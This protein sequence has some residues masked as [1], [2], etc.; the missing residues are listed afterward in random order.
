MDTKDSPP[1]SVPD[2]STKSNDD[3]EDDKVEVGL[4]TWLA[5]GAGC[6]VIFSSFYNA[7]GISS[8]T[9]TVAAA[10]GGTE[11]A[12][13]ITWL[14][15]AFECTVLALASSISSISDRFGRREILI[16]GSL[17]CCG[18]SSL[19]PN[20]F[21][22]HVVI[23]GSVMTGG[24]F[25]NQ[26]IYYS[27]PSEVLPRRYRGIGQTLT[28]SAGA[29]GAT[30][31]LLLNGA[32]IKIYGVQ[33]FRYNYYVGCFILLCSTAMV[34]FFYDPIKK[35]E[36]SFL[37]VV[38]EDLDLVGSALVI[39][40]AVPFLIG[41]NWGGGAFPWAS[42]QTILCL[43]IGGASLIAFG[44]HL[45]IGRN[46]AISFV[47]LFVEGVIFLVFGLFYP[48]MVNTLWEKE[49]PFL[50]VLYL[51]PFWIAFSITSPM[52]GWYSRKYRDLKRPLVVGWGLILVANIMFIFMDETS[53]KMAICADIIGGIGFSVPLALLN[54]SAQLSTPK[55]LLGV[56]TG[57]IMAIRAFGTG[58]G[59]IIFVAILKAKL[60]ELLPKLI[61]AAVVGAGLPVDSIA[62][63]VGGIAEGN[64]TLASSAPG[65]TAEYHY[66]WY[67]CLPFV[68]LAMGLSLWLDAP[69]IK[70]EM[71]WSTD[72]A[73]EV[74]KHHHDFDE[75][76]K[77]E[78][79]I[80]IE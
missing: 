26:G 75:S 41:M 12:N 30:A 62:A 58:V 25:V 54:V 66:G 17:L 72:N 68:I 11:V 45:W 27:I 29:L 60:T 36:K 20:D 5:V 59:A 73:V 21:A 71:N 80:Q 47:G 63:V 64:L 6:A 35:P 48:Q 40:F 43:G 2:V 28:A 67:A 24:L 8:F 10:I 74:V 55:E 76:V 3:D 61:I 34:Y 22:P 14:P 78:K 65:A 16:Y 37:R 38:T 44:V 9:P 1:A 56:G 4:R 18:K 7:I 32:F 23:V 33:G 39:M 31:T 46:Y 69:V 50:Q 51:V 49:D 52:A 79:D 70:A 77:Q 53:H 42:Y 13:E 15:N 19:L 57:N